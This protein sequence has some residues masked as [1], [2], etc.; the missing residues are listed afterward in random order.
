MITNHVNNELTLDKQAEMADRLFETYEMQNYSPQN[1]AAVSHN[2]E[3]SQN[4]V[5]M[6]INMIQNL[7]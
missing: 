6:L 4:S 2:N 7:Q 3:I 5:E 1:V